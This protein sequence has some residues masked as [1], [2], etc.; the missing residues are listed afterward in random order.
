MTLIQV[1]LWATLAE[2]QTVLWKE[3]QLLSW[4]YKVPRRLFQRGQHW[5]DSKCCCGG[6]I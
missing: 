6:D 3:A 2:F 5:L 1:K 4:L